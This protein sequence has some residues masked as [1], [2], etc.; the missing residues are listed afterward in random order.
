MEP[1]DSSSSSVDVPWVLSLPVDDGDDSC[2]SDDSFV[3]D[4]EPLVD[5]GNVCKVTEL[6]STSTATAGSEVSYLQSIAK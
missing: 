2:F 1:A 6:V 3:L 5:S 4:P